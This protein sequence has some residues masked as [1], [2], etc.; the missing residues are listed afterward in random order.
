MKNEISALDLYYLEKELQE[1]VGGRID[2]IYQEK[3]SFL[4]TMHVRGKGKFMLKINP[5]NLY[6]TEDK[7]E[8]PSTPPG[9]CTL[10]RI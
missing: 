9:Y 5:N 1:I 6:L 3:R 2:K 8:F 10:L 4:I 7:E